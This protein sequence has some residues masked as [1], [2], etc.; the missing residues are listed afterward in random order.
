MFSM[1]IGNLSP[2]LIRGRVAVCG[3]PWDMDL[4]AILLSGYLGE[5][6]EMH[7]SAWSLVARLVYYYRNIAITFDPPSQSVVNIAGNRV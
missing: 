6:L 2:P 4:V 1:L 7:G 5:K 3:F